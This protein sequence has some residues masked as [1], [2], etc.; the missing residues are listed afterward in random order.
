MGD[1]ANGQTES[2]ATGSFHFL[3][4]RMHHFAAARGETVI[5]VHGQGPLT[6]TT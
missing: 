4:G 2:L 6:S 3:P 5:E 1:K